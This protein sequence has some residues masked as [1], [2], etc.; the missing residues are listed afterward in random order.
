MLAVRAIAAVE[1]RSARNSAI[2]RPP[3]FQRVRIGFAAFD[4]LVLAAVDADHDLVAAARPAAQARI[5]HTVGLLG[6]FQPFGHPP[7]ELIG[8]GLGQGS[9]GMGQ[10]QCQGDPPHAALLSVRTGRLGTAGTL[11]RG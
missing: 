8:I 5:G 10:H 6:R 11:N 7:V 1:L 9:C 2:E 4:L 3:P